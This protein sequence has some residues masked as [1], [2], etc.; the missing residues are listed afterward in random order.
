VSPKNGP[1]HPAS[2][3]CFI[4]RPPSLFLVPYCKAL[5]LG[6]SVLWLPVGHP[7]SVVHAISSSTIPTCAPGA[8]RHPTTAALLGHCLVVYY[9][10]VLGHCLYRPASTTTSGKKHA[11]CYLRALQSRCLILP[12]PLKDKQRLIDFGP[13]LKPCVYNRKGHS[14]PRTK[15]YP[16]GQRAQTIRHMFNIRA[17]SRIRPTIPN[18]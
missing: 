15:I 3:S 16:I 7:A 2:A 6:L 14:T 10:T 8:V 13:R 18:L 11:Q 1:V 5:S 4:G 12:T 17:S 9:L